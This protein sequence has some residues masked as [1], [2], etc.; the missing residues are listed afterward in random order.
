[1][2]FL[3]MG[4]ALTVAL[5]YLIRFPMFLPFLEYDPGDIP[6]YFCTFLLGPVAGFV[7]TVVA[8]VIQGLT[9]S[10]ASGWIGI[11]MHIMATG[12]FTLTAGIIYSRRRNTPGLFLGASAGLIVTVITMAVW[13]LLLTP[14]FMNAP[15]SA[16][17]QLLPLIIAFN[18]IKVSINAGTAILIYKLLYKYIKI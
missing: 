11:L 1:M 3:G 18:V 14:V 10:A 16:V 4:A 7:L 5:I 15:V 13:N 17:I 2:T 12:A 6:I 9:V 8:S